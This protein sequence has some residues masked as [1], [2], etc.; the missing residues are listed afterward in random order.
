MSGADDQSESISKMRT[1]GS[2]ACV[3]GDARS[4]EVGGRNGCGVD[5]CSKGTSVH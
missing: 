1:S 5:R 3:N 4:A 2:S